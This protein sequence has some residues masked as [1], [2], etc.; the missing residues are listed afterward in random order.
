MATAYAYKAV[1][2]N[3][4]SA[5]RITWYNK[6]GTPDAEWAALSLDY[7]IGNTVAPDP[8]V[9]LAQKLAS[10]IPG[11]RAHAIPWP[12][13]PVGSAGVHAFDSFQLAH[14]YT[15]AQQWAEAIVVGVNA[16][17]SGTIDVVSTAG[18]PT[19]GT[20]VLGVIHIT[21]A[22]GV[23]IHDSATVNV[24]STAGFPSSGSFV[25][26]G[27]TVTYSGKTSTS[28]TGCSNHAPTVGGEYV[29]AVPTTG[30]ITYTGKTAT[31]F[32]GCSAHDAT[33][34]GET[35]SRLGRLVQLR[36]DTADLLFQQYNDFCAC[37]RLQLRSCVV[38]GEA[39]RDPIT[40]D[41]VY[42]D[43]WA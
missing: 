2:P 22:T 24:G 7:S 5:G 19:S 1:T 23:N 36:Y 26:E 3:W 41:W 10:V 39:Y 32:T 12:N 25:M 14:F 28:F 35:I 38:T 29:I 18:F 6:I 20:F 42:T 43:D 21:T 40:G 37:R 9:E 34:G 11:I 15:G 17:D 27:V 33:L 30:T 8:A 13:H 4:K 16:T 31:T